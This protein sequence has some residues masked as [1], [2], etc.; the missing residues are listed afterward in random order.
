MKKIATIVC[1]LVSFNGIA[2]PKVSSDKI[3][4][5]DCDNTAI[6]Q[7][8][9]ADNRSAT[10]CEV[11]LD[12]K[13]RAAFRQAFAKLMNEW[14]DKDWT[15]SINSNSE[16]KK[17]TNI[18]RGTER[19]FFDPAFADAGNFYLELNM[20][21]TTA[22][23]KDYFTRYAAL[24]DEMKSD[25]SGAAYQKFA[26]HYYIVR[27]A[28]NICINTYVN[29]EFGKL[30]IYKGDVKPIKVPGAAYA[31]RASHVQKG[32]G[33]E[34][35]V[36]ACLIV[37][38]NAKTKLTKHGDGTQTLHVESAFPVKTSRLTVQHVAIRIECNAE[39]LE[40]V[41]RDVDWQAIAK[42]VGQ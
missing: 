36:D 3:P 11:Q 24:M 16:L 29:N 1:L 2:Q 23:Y 30:Y 6:D 25:A 42:L 10:P 17:I 8:V 32:P 15:V 28:T 39:L 19:Q 18:G 21:P 37:F 41:I 9:G 22:A 34:E 40:K 31:A 27:S 38:G 20:N 33:P 14:N 12:Q 5:S 35:S 26:A 7:F 4:G 13:I